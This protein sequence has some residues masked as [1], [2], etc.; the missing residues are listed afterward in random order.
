MSIGEGILL[1][2][3]R[4]QGS[5]DYHCS[6]NE[7]TFENACSLLAHEY[8]HFENLVS[9]KK[10]AD[11]GCGAGYQSAALAVRYNSTVV[12]IDTNQRS[13]QQAIDFAKSQHIPKERLSFVDRITD[14]MEGDFD[15]VISQNS[16]EH[17]NDPIMSLDEMKKLIKK[18]GKI[19]ITFGPPWFAPYGSHMHFFCKVPWINILFSEKTVMNVR[20]IFRNDGAERY[21]DVESGLSKMTVCKFEK[22][23]SSCELEIT[24]KK[25]SCVKG[26]DWLAEYR[27]IR[28]LFINRIS[29]I[30]VNSQK[31]MVENQ[32]GFK[33]TH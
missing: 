3:S 2:I 7:W 30:I 10:I 6:K 18:T 19:L 21:E 16:F 32:G 20:K 33:I 23:I 9:G 14:Q 11:F 22:I 25:Y 17:F 12:G 1:F 27:I 4:S 13:L 15:A 8:P 29:V 28:E 26:I 31:I 5:A 24:H